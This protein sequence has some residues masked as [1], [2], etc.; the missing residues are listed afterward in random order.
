MP[1][2]GA[3]PVSKKR[4]VGGKREA[5]SDTGGSIDKAAVNQYINGHFDEV[6]ACYEHRLKANSFLE[7]EL[8]LNIEIA[9]TGKV[10]GITANKDTIRD[11]EMLSCIKKVV[12]RWEFPKPKGS[13]VTIAKTFTFRKSAS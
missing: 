7:G 1:D 9:L 2:A 10:T 5:F 3:S 12:R 11:S 4:A 6:K 13:S 8:D